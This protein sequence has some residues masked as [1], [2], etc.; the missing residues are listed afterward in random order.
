V[1]D[2]RRYRKVFLRLWNNPDFRALPDGEKV[3]TVYLF[4]GPQTNRIGLYQFSFGKASEDLN[5]SVETVRR[6]FNRVCQVFGWETDPR[7]SVLW[8]PSWWNFNAP[9]TGE[10]KNWKGCLSDVNE[11]PRTPLI[12]KFCHNLENVPP[13]VHGLFAEVEHK[14]GIEHCGDRALREHCTGSGRTQ[15]Q[16]Q[17][18]EI[19]QEQEQDLA[20]RRETRA[21]DSE[22]GTGGFL[23]RFCELY[24]KHRNGARY[25]V[26]R[27]RHVPLIRSLLRT[28]GAVRLEKLTV[29]LLTATADEWLNRTDRGIEVLHGKVNWLEDRLAAYE[30]EHGEI[31]IAS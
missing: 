24:S 23:R 25:H 29:V 12:L 21:L 16:E 2:R 28:Y 1:I 11:L 9:T 10:I 5:A 19:E 4:T 17:E 3:M 20:A 13:P 6:R 14:H 18:Q 8:I 31:R 26:V 27:T 30:R 7:T 15:E 22:L